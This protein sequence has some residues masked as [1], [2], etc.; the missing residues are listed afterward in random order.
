MK[1]NI[2]KVKIDTIIRK[3]AWTLSDEVSFNKASI[4]FLKIIHNEYNN[5]IVQKSNTIN[6][7]YIYERIL[8]IINNICGDCYK[9]SRDII[10][11]I[12]NMKKGLYIESDIE[13]IDKDF[14][15]IGFIISNINA[16]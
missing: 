4:E 9:I 11:V 2:E 12:E 1:N 16:R 15:Y 6:D 3:R 5:L 7:I 8:D 13:E 10:T 14:I